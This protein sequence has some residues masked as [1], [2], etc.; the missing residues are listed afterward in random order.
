M[1][2]I[3]SFFFET[4]CGS[5][6]IAAAVVAGSGPVVQPSNGVIDVR[7]EGPFVRLESEME[8]LMCTSNG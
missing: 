3:D 6:S 1:R 4:S 7:V 5:G 8:V 2:A